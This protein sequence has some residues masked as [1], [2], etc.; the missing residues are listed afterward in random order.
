MEEEIAPEMLQIATEKRRELIEI[1]SEVD[2]EL[3][4]KFLSDEPISVDELEVCS[5]PILYEGGIA[6]PKFTGC[7]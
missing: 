5:T 3:A 6:L 7:G 4:E 2:E 1:V